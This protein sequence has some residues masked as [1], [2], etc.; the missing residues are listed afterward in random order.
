MS[1]YEEKTEQATPR[2]RQKAREKGQIARSRDLGSIAAV[3]GIVLVFMAGGG[4]FMRYLATVTGRHLSFQP[5]T[6]PFAALRAASIETMLLILPFLGAAL[7]LGV[8]ATLMQGGV[9]LKPL[10][11]KTDSL[12]PLNGLK[13]IFSLNGLAD[14]LK[15]IAKFLIGGCLVYFV[16]RKDLSGL[17]SLMRLDAGEL[18]RT[19]G[20]LIMKAVLYGFFCFLVFGV[21]D[22]FIERWRFEHSI[23]M[24]KEELREEMRESEGNPMLKS[25]IRSLQREMA[26]KRM[27]HEVP[28][29]TVVITNPTHLAVALRYEESEG[30]APRVVAKGAGVVA[31]KIKETARKHKVPIVE[32]KPLARALYKQLDIGAHI[33]E[34]LY[35]AVAKI[36]AYIYRLKGASR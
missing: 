14:F 25:R 26:R 24:G 23:R 36:L 29:A 3:G 28:K 4:H 6:D 13:K 31:E 34:E 16:I 18:A 33:P 8:A 27:M 32:D 10:E 19:S 15:S 11:I 7:S 9:V 5:G 20:H 30:K 12:N 21:V 17:P 2:R 22:F 35:R 1:E